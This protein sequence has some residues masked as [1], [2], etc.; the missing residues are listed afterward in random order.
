M[1]MQRVALH[2]PTQGQSVRAFLALKDSATGGDIDSTGQF[3][4][5]AALTQVIAQLESINEALSADGVKRG[6]DE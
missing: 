6:N 2:A 5:Y 3:A 1:T 4:I